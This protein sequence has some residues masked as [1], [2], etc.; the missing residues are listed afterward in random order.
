MQDH[1]RATQTTLV[2]VETRRTCEPAAPRCAWPG[3]GRR[4]AAL[5]FGLLPVPRWRLWRHSVPAGLPRP[6]R[7]PLS[8]RLGPWDLARHLRR[9]P[10]SGTSFASL[11]WG[12]T[13]WAPGRSCWLG[14][15]PDFPGCWSCWES[16]PDCFF[17]NVSFPGGVD[18]SP[19]LSGAWK[20]HP[21]RL[22]A[23]NC[24]AVLGSRCGRALAC[25][26][27]PPLVTS[28]KRRERRA[29]SSPP[30]PPCAAGSVGGGD[31]QR[32]AH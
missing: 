23:C 19:T 24:I 10:R 9:L 4:G 17:Q 3:S 2:G 6:V 31:G 25:V 12:S 7:P 28:S 5:E 29:T 18:C 26:C 22:H 1:G 16:P 8:S 11:P 32:E 27:W 14:G 20:P 13:G 30:G 21:G 15:V